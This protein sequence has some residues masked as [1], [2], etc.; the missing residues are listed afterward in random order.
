VWIVLRT[1][2]LQVPTLCVEQ[3]SPR[4]PGQPELP[5]DEVGALLRVEQEPTGILRT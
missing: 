3:D 4:T 5:A 2:V 1:L